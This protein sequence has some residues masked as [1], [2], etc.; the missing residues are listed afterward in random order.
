MP[1]LIGVIAA[2][3]FAAGLV[4]DNRIAGSVRTFPETGER[5]DVL[6]SMASQEIAQRIQQQI[7]IVSQNESVDSIGIGFPGI[8]REGI[9]EESPN[10]PQMKGE[11]LALL[12]KS[13][14]VQPPVHILNDA[15]AIA[16]GIAATHGL[17]DKIVR[18]WF[19]GHG[20]GFGR[21]PQTEGAGEGG[22][23]VVT[24]DPK[25]RYCPCG[26]VGHLEGIMGHRAMR[27]RFLDLEPEEVFEEAKQG[28]ARCKAFVEMW[29]R[30]LAAATAS[31][32][33]MEGPGKFFITGPNA[34]HAQPE[35]IQIFLKEMVRMS[36]LQGSAL[37]VVATSDEVAI[38]GAAVSSRHIAE[39]R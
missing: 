28:D 24:L 29:N 5:D 33:H 20:I 6:S 9:V 2:E 26:G 21:Y 34:G 25:E 15:D 16:A 35:L 10:L 4:E 8:I 18:V 22:H 11:N 39:P 13:A 32:I 19:L 31:N 7:E 12:L 23:T 14:G 37:E 3:H 36:P 30:A 1:R 17:L 38:V 27:M